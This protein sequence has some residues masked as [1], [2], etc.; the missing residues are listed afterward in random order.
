MVQELVL[1]KAQRCIDEV[2][3]PEA[4]AD[5][6]LFYSISDFLDE[7]VRWV[8]DNVPLEILTCIPPSSTSITV[9]DEGVVRVTLKEPMHR[10]AYVNVS[11]WAHP[12]RKFIYD[13]D[14]LYLQQSNRVLRG[15]PSRPVVAILDSKHIE[16]YSTRCNAYTANVI[17]KQAMYDVEALPERLYD[18]TAWKLAEIVL[19]SISDS[20]SAQMCS[21]RVD[22]I[23][24][25]F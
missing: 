23:M 12:V 13:T 8:V 19:M 18:I 21:I 14:P 6:A 11:D 16:L 17:I 7:A 5:N 22:D 10:L 1:A 20:A 15:N 24:K 9:S 25:Q 4:A 3:I 2:L